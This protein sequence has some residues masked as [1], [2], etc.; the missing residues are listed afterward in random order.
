MRP[1]YGGYSRGR[2]APRFIDQLSGNT[3]LSKEQLLCAMENHELCNLFQECSTV[4]AVMN[5]DLTSLCRSVTGL[6]S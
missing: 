3:H 2:P 6:A 5:C 4:I 1:I